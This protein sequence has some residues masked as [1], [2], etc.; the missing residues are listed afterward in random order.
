ME[1]LQA[2]LIL[3]V[4][5]SLKVAILLAAAGLLAVVFRKAPAR[6]RLLIWTVALVGALALPWLGATIPSNWRTTVQIPALPTE[7]AGLKA[8]AGLAP[9]TRPSMHEQVPAMPILETT[10]HVPA[11]S[12]ETDWTLILL[13]AWLLPASGFLLRFAA[14]SMHVRRL[15]RHAVE[16]DAAE[17]LSALEVATGQARLGRRIRLLSS[18]AVSSPMTWG[19]FAPVIMI[20]RSASSWS[21]E[22]MQLVLLHECVHIRRN[23]WLLRRLA[24]VACAVYWYNPLIWLAASKLSLEQ[25]F[26]CDDEILASGAVPSSYADHLVEIARSSSFPSHSPAAALDM[27]RKSGLE[28]RLMSILNQAR[29]RRSLF[30][31]PALI[32]IAAL[33]PLLAAVDR[34]S[35]SRSVEEIKEELRV[36]KEQLRPFEEQLESVE[37]RLRPFE[38]RMSEVEINME[39]IELEMEELEKLLEP[40]EE[41]IAT[42]ELDLEPLELEM[43]ELEMIL[44]P[45][46]LEIEALTDELEPL[47]ESDLSQVAPLLEKVEEIMSRMQPTLSEISEVQTRFA[48]VQELIDEVMTGMQPEI[49]RIVEHHLKFEPH[50]QILQEVQEEM[51]PV[52]EEMQIIM[53]QAAPLFRKLQRLEEELQEVEEGDTIAESAVL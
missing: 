24:C 22:R 8:G 12:T 19:V 15:A 7:G 45:L 30:L 35:S 37:S 29:Q 52:L 46:E 32:L 13:L 28:V 27:A 20:P 23:D 6:A 16:L 41:R 44:E 9:T 14:G 4:M 2:V 33:I 1:N 25:E 34:A 49:D 11:S 43:E 48:P 40:M 51:Q 17:W 5:A 18:D 21:R 31:F 47:D 42:L 36:V 3:L 39:P 10:A 50:M 26:A 38:E 53:E